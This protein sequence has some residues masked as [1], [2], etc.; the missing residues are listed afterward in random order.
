MERFLHQDYTPEDRAR[1]LRDSADFT[2]EDSTYTRTLTPA[3]L[4][5]EREQ[6]SEDCILRS[7]IEDEK[8]TIM[9]Q[10]KNRLDPVNE[11]IQER[12][13]KIKTKQETISGALHGFKDHEEG[14]VFFY[15][16][17]GEQVYSRR[18]RPSEAQ[19][20]VMTALREA[21]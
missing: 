11:T 18:L 7:E 21:K 13:Q 12:L 17:N 4:D 3:E 15:D 14:M 6:L 16:D 8:K 2:E 20:T 9:K 19:K 5:I 10:F 1:I